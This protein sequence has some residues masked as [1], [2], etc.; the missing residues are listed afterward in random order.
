MK[1]LEKKKQQINHCWKKIRTAV[2][3]AIR[4]SQVSDV[5]DWLYNIMNI[6]SLK[7]KC[8]SQCSKQPILIIKKIRIKKKFRTIQKKHFSSIL[9]F[10]YLNEN[11]PT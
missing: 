9:F 4:G 7:G 3:F 8:V 2:W 6:S 10:N 11:I 1:I 5:F